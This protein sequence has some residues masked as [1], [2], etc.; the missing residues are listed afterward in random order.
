MGPKGALHL[1]LERDTI[2]A[3]PLQST[4]NER[5]YAAERQHEGAVNQK[6]FACAATIGDPAHNGWDQ[7]RAEAL[8]RLAQAYNGALLMTAHGTR[9]H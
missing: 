2:G 5:E 8:T 9:L 4:G 3:R 7:D 1:S 6:A